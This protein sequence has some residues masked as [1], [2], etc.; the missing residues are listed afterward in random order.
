LS[1]ELG[2]ERELKGKELKAERKNTWNFE[3]Q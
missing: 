2:A 1:F 3:L